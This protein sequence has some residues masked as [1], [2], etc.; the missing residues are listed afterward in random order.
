MNM[1]IINWVSIYILYDLLCHR[2]IILLS[3]YFQ[4]VERNLFFFLAPVEYS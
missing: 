3:S 2:E 4:A 1:G